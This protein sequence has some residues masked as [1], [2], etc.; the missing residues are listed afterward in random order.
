MGSLHDPPLLPQLIAEALHRLQNEPCINLGGTTASYADVR[1]QTS[2]TIQAQRHLGLVRGS[3]IAVL[4]KNR[5]EVLS[6]IAATFLNGGVLTPLHPLRSLDE[7]AAALQAQLP[8]LQLPSAC[9]DVA[10]RARRREGW[11]FTVMEA[12]DPDE[13]LGIMS[14][15][16]S[17]RR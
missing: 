8:E 15:R 10:A 13:F 3:R 7:R 17:P 16:R 5:P 14:A 2:C 4:S 11:I 9:G 6:N 1:Q 12:F